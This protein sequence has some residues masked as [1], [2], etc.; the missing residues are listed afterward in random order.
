MVEELV[1]E[2][3]LAGRGRDG[4]AGVFLQLLRRRDDRHRAPAEDEA[5]PHEDGVA[6][7]RGDGAGLL[8]RVGDAARRLFDAGLLDEGAEEVAVLGAGDVRGRRPEDLHAGRL[9]PRGEVER[10]LSPELDDRAV[11][12]L[13]LVDLHHVL[14][15]QR[16]EVEPVARVVVRGD[17]LGVRVHHHHLEPPLPQ[18]E[19]RVAAAPVE[20]DALPDPVRPA[21]EDEDAAAAPPRVAG[22][23]SQVAGLGFGLATWDLRLGT[24]PAVGRIEIRRRRLE[25]A[26]AGVD[27]AELGTDAEGEAPRADVL[28]AAPA[29][30]R[31]LRVR[32]AEDFRLAEK[33]RFFARVAGRQVAGR[34][35]GFATFSFRLPTCNL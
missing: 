32:Q 15:R 33:L 21:A 29:R 6:E 24:V 7:A 31:D 18:R 16:L 10:G 30:L 3:R 25:L 17:R 23:R 2:N 26:G 35:S 28:F 13:A 8:D 27:R 1:D 11:A 22:R 19:R 5:R 9:E 12:P 4:L 34:R 14:E 20:L